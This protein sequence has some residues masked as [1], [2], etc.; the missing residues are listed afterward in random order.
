MT[1]QQHFLRGHRCK[2]CVEIPPIRQKPARCQQLGPA[3]AWKN[4]KD[5]RKFEMTYFSKT[6][7]LV[8]LRQNDKQTQKKKPTQHV[9]LIISS[10]WISQLWRVWEHS[11]ADVTWFFSFHLRVGGF[12]S[13]LSPLLFLIFMMFLTRLAPLTF[14]NLS[15]GATQEAS[16][17]D[18]VCP[19]PFPL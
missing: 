1:F 19:I 8:E 9:T 11:C 13:T 15:F 17:W 3:Q 6:L 14:A 18:D 4:K 16:A 5:W 2:M 7:F 12:C 10:P